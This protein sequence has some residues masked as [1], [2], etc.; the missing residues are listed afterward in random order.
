[1]KFTHLFLIVGVATFLSCQKSEFLVEEKPDVVKVVDEK[2][3]TVV[4]EDTITIPV[5]DEIIKY[6]EYTD[7][8]K[9]KLAPGF[10]KYLI[11]FGIDKDPTPNGYVLY[12]YI[13]DIDS[14]NIQETF[15]AGEAT[16]RGI[17]GFTNLRIFKTLSLT[18]DKID[19][20]NNAKLESFQY[21]QYPHCMGCNT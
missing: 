14:L 5:D 1:M 19:F 3:S 2:D 6:I 17:E 8:S 20:S 4:E 11:K 15:D 13:R 18:V 9:V 16:L 12:Q 10:E 7:T 21:M